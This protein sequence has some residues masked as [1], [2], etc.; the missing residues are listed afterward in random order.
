AI[1]LCFAA[2]GFVLSGDAPLIR[3]YGVMP[4]YL[5]IG[6]S[7]SARGFMAP[8]YQSIF[9]QLLP[10]ALYAN[11]A[12][13][14]SNTWQS[15]AVLGPAIGRLIYGIT[16]LEIAFGIAVAL[17]FGSFFLFLRVPVKET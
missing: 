17:M 1:S 4:V 10:R 12:T 2:V 9:P 5:A 15:A 13:W 11:G 3:Q 14:G 7:G 6:C 8:A 16:N